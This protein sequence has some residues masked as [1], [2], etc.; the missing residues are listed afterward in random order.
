[1]KQRQTFGKTLRGIGVNTTEPPEG[2]TTK[3][4]IHEKVLR[5]HHLIHRRPKA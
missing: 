2:Y 5:M 1:M 3:E 4:G